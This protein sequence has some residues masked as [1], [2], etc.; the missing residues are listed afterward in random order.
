RGG[1][2]QGAVF[3]PLPLALAALHRRLKASFDPHGILNR[4]RLYPEF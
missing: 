1:D 4:G 3:Q 2:R